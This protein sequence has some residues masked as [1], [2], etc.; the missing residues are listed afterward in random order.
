MNILEQLRKFIFNV[1]NIYKLKIRTNEIGDIIYLSVDYK[2]IKRI[3]KKKILIKK[4]FVKYINSSTREAT[5]QNI[6]LNRRLHGFNKST[7]GIYFF[8]I[9]NKLK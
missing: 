1:E 3:N 5:T 6:V 8:W 4:S 2:I 7:K 9:G